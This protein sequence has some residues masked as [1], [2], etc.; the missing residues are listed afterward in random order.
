MQGTYL[1]FIGK[2]FKLLQRGA[3]PSSLSPPTRFFKSARLDEEDK[4]DE[5]AAPT[6][7]RPPTLTAPHYT[8]AT[9]L[10]A[11]SARFSSTR[12]LV[13]LSTCTPSLRVQSTRLSTTPHTRPTQ[14]VP[15]SSSSTRA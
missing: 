10:A 8:S 15:I 4:E 1:S 11:F 6:T 14:P 9:S 12:L 2:L 5:D 3:P 7:H 13:Q